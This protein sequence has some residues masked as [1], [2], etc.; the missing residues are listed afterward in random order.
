MFPGDYTD[1]GGYA[2]RNGFTMIDRSDCLVRKG[3][4]VGSTPGFWPGHRWKDIKPEEA[5]HV[6]LGEGPLFLGLYKGSGLVFFNGD[7]LSPIG[8]LYDY[9]VH[10]YE[11]AGQRVIAKIEQ[12]EGRNFLLAK[13]IMTNN[14]IWSG[15]SG[16]EV[17][18]GIKDD[19]E[20]SPQRLWLN[21]RLKT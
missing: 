14:I 4:L 21:E 16:P 6:V 15:Y 3:A 19:V 12:H 10:R 8:D 13:M 5:W 9:Q 7:H 20:T 2:Y 17:G 11:I 1:Y 18:A